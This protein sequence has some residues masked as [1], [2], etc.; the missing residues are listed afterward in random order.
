MSC[1]CWG[2][3]DTDGAMVN[4]IDDGG[5]IPD[6]DAQDTCWHNGQALNK[7]LNALQ[8]GDTFV[9]PANRT[10]HLMGGVIARNLRNNVLRFDGQ[11]VYSGSVRDWPRTG[12][13]NV[14]DCLTLSNATD[15][16]LTSSTDQIKS[17]ATDSHR[18][19]ILES[20]EEKKRVGVEKDVETDADLGG[21][22][23][24]RGAVWWGVPGVG[25][26]VHGENR[27]KLL[28]LGD[29]CVNLTVEHL[30]LKDSPYWTFLASGVVGLEV[31]GTKIHASRTPYDGH[32]L[33][34]LTAFNTDGFDVTGRNVHI[35]DCEVWNQDDTIAV[36]DD[37]Q[38]MVFERIKASGVGLTIGSIGG[39]VVRNIT[40][41]DCTM[42]QTYKGIYLKFRDSAVGDGGT[43][44]DVTFENILIDEPSQWPIWIGPAQQSDSDRLCA[45][46]PC[47][48]CWPE[49]AA[50][51][52]ECMAPAGSTYANITLRNV[53]VR[54][55]KMSPGVLLA[56]ASA[57]MVDVLFED[58]VVTD[59]PGDG[60][61]GDDY[62]LCENVV[63]GVAT[64]ATWPVQPCFEDR[65]TTT[66]AARA[67]AAVRPP[68]AAAAAAGG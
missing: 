60:V 48:L 28:V 64:G 19:V 43:I 31:R 9:V 27:P 33:V 16:L 51:G 5:A 24:G 62:Y 36:K 22:M 30:L 38:D 61:W 58:V 50:E 4:F 59:P 10:F 3:T 49:L 12:E 1:L 34:D 46:H 11:I 39:S 52:A 41:R 23:D 55:P 66:T 47:S 2:S 68:V 15:V 63:G 21:L 18:A 44:A 42:P 53:T 6:D 65:T 8:E 29:A 40:F 54:S 35:H 25:Y 37:S 32:D 20:K 57:P 17:Y 56:N 7:T 13:G 26:L 67:A 14:L 45:A